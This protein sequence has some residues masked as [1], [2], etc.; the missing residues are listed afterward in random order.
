MAKGMCLLIITSNVNR[1]NTPIKRHSYLTGWKN[2]I[3][4]YATYARLT[5]E[6]KTHTESE[7]IR[8]RYFM[9]VEMGSLGNSTHIRQ[10]HIDFKTKYIYL[11]H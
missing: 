6:L 4:V 7:E 10:T 9:Q 1:Q 8:K 3:H 11:G 5:S 2:K